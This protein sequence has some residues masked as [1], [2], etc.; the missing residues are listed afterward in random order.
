MTC[1]SNFTMKIPKLALY[2]NNMLYGSTGT[3]TLVNNLYIGVLCC[4]IQG[5]INKSSLHVCVSVLNVFMHI[6]A[7]Y[8]LNM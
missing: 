3:C 4:T 1:T 5:G 8:M 6:C 7:L 2:E